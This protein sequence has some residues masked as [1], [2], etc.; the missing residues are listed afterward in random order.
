MVGEPSDTKLKLKAAETWG[1]LLFMISEFQKHPNV[2]NRRSLLEGA[3]SLEQMV[4]VWQ[5]GGGRLTDVEIHHSFAH[6]N[7]FLACTSDE[8]YAGELEQPKRHLTA[9]L[10]RDLRHFGN[11]RWFANWHDESLNKVLR[12]TCRFV[13]RHTFDATVLSGMRK[14]LQDL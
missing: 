14:Q 11:P 12:R 1:V 2:E 6:F 4:R 7:R 9:H 13:H 3:Q 10:L 8:P 5:Q